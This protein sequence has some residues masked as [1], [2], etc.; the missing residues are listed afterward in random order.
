MSDLEGTGRIL[1]GR[2]FS[3]G[4]VQVKELCEL[5]ADRQKN[6]IFVQEGKHNLI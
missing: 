6:Y 5:K 4:V 3:V 2:G 1:A